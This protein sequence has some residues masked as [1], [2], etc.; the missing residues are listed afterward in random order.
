MRLLKQTTLVF[1][2]LFGFH[3]QI[4]SAQEKQERKMTIQELAD[5]LKVNNIQLELANT[6]VKVAEARIGEVKTNRLPNIG[7]E[8]IGMYL[9]DVD[10]YNTH[11]SKIQSV[12]IPNFGHQFNLNA[13]QLIYGGGR[14]NKAVA[15]AEMNKT[16]VDGQRNDTDQ[17]IKLNAS[18]LYLNLY[19]LQHQ[20]EILENNKELAEER[21]KN[22][23]DFFEQDMVTKNEVLRAEVLQ[24]QLEQSIL[25][26]QNAIDITNK[27]LTL[28]A[29]LDE[30][31][32]IIPDV[33]NIN[34]TIRLQ[35]E[36]YFRQIAFGNN[37][38]LNISDTQIAIAEK[39]LEL[40]KSDRL[41]TLAG[42][43]GYGATRPMT[44]SSPAIDAYSASYQV[45]LNL[46]YN[47]ESLFKNGK[48]EAVDKIL[49]DQA[50]Q[51]KIAV[52]QNIEADVNTA[53]NNYHQAIKQREV[54]S[55]NEKAADENYRI[56]ELKY[57]NQ[58]V[59]VAEIID[60]SNT[61]LQA[62]LQTLDDETDI[63]VNYIRLLRVTG[64]L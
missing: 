45:G 6:S 46:S 60:A 39:N 24:R 50:E 21:T 13:N 29:G 54:S 59:T 1:L 37:P 42:F 2:V 19:N 32:L 4:T 8:M 25:Q 33:S 51:Q 30:N 3:S 35:D 9:S 49:I 10:I 14:I 20:K 63:I 48:K 16:L 15:L 31:I 64:Q 5:S 34:H 27:N 62:E 36:T 43:A 11:W 52:M 22:V 61:K 55:I 58:L 41:P 18:E 57:K 44:S 23:N 7:A 47:I 28:M 38:R 40:T 17:S 26:T 53:F 56:T 12:N